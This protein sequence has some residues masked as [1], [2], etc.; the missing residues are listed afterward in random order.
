MAYISTLRIDLASCCCLLQCLKRVSGSMRCLDKTEVSSYRNSHQSF[1]EKVEFI[2]EYEGELNVEG[3]RRALVSLA[4]R[5][6]VLRATVRECDRCRHGY[7]WDLS[8]GVYPNFMV[9]DGGWDAMRDLSKR[10]KD[11]VEYDKNNSN[12][13]N[14]KVLAYGSSES[15]CLMDL[16]LFRELKRGYILLG[17]SHMIFAAA[18]LHVYISELCKFYTDIVSGNEIST[19]QKPFP[20]SKEALESKYSERFGKGPKKRSPRTESESANSR[21]QFWGCDRV[22]K[23]SNEATSFMI[24]GARENRASVPSV[25]GS[26]MTLALITSKNF[27]NI[28][29]VD[30]AVSVDK[31][32]RLGLK[33]TETF[34]SATAHP[35]ALNLSSNVEMMT[36]ANRLQTKIDKLDP[37]AP[38]PLQEVDIVLNN[39]GV[40]PSFPHLESLRWVDFIIE[41]WI[42]QSDNWNDFDDKQASFYH[43]APFP[44]W[45]VFHTFNGELRIWYKLREDIE[46][47][48]ADEFVNHL[49][50]FLN[51][52]DPLQ[53][54]HLD[55]GA[56][57]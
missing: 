33:P 17:I 14:G 41:S 54:V 37:N 29:S 55:R 31:G 47:K 35:V 30:F 38:M 21:A 25:I 4:D 40:F 8:E 51:V 28:S 24:A 15:N 23:L 10:R 49:D 6:P 48:V 13:A 7:E 20:I 44:C 3:L 39:Q 43:R 36:L 46:D 12:S 52:T 50:K 19:N 57:W 1:D 34:H 5:Y 27:E 32:R 56:S 18:Q 2:I 22:V 26:A 53:I 45:L 11:R 16:V 42:R 9:V